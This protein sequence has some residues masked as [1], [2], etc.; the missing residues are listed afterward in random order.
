MYEDFMESLMKKNTGLINQ[1]EKTEATI[2]YDV[3]GLSEKDMSVKVIGNIIEVKIDGE[4][5]FRSFSV[6]EK[7]LVPLAYYI[8]EKST[9]ALKNGILTI[10]IPKIKEASKTLEIKLL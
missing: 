2:S 5:P 4:S 6:H 10:T 9:V 8:I 3:A 1:N 7:I